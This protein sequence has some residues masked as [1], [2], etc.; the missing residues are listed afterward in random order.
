MRKKYQRLLAVILTWV[1]C[2]SLMQG[3]VRAEILVEE[4]V[5]GLTDVVVESEDDL[6]VESEVKTEEEEQTQSHLPQTFT[7]VY[8]NPLYRDVISEEDLVKPKDTETFQS[9]EEQVSAENYI[10]VNKASELFR[11][12]MKKR[13]ETI[14][15]NV[16]TDDITQ[17]MYEIPDAAMAHTGNPKEGDYLQWQYRG[18][19]CSSCYYFL[20]GKYY[21]EIIYTLTY[22]TN[23]AQ[24]AEL[25]NAIASVKSS[26]GLDSTSLSDY[27]KIKAIYDYLTENIT[28]D[29]TNLDDNDYWLKYTA[30]A[31]M[32]NRTAV[33]QGYAVLFYR[34][35][36]DAG[37][38][39]RVI[40]GIGNGGAH[41]W[42]IVKLGSFYYNIDA[43]WDAG[44]K[45]YDYFLK[46]DTNFENHIRD[47]SY[48]TAS[49]Y[50][51]YPMATSNYDA[52]HV[53][54]YGA[55]KIVKSATCIKE[56][57]QQRICITCENKETRAVNKSNHTWGAW[58]TIT[59]ATVFT[60][61][62][63]KR[64]C[65]QCN[66]A[67]E[68]RFSGEKL[69]KTISVTQSS[70][71][72]QMKQ[73]TTAFRV[74]FAN[75]DSVKSWT[76]SNTRVVKISGK[77]NGTCTITAQSKTGSATITITLK[78]GLE[79]SV[80]VNVQKGAVAASSLKLPSTKVE[81]KKG[82]TL[83]LKPI[84]TPITSQSKVTYSTS[85]KSVATVS[86]SGVIKGVKKGTAKITV[87]AGTKKVVCTVAV[88]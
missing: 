3:T 33:C 56:G 30:Y 82:K 73:K 63:Q 68:T 87:K 86:S 42:N 12:K 55:W 69:K 17:V 71:T 66:D 40:T 50:K 5:Q 36:L 67:Y 13:S 75:G 15:L 39:V 28:Y 53:H 9:E 41:A 52:N 19:S 81:V 74:T 47:H 4:D 26:L 54:Q 8:V 10:S 34:M 88:K 14:V 32:I 57:M 58:K 60:P 84:V 16:V 6:V 83:T 27:Q 65:T 72:M 76:S 20:E 77:S 78:S 48:A 23:A 24:E 31:A 80:K 18:W 79:K 29:Y 49:F 62:K 21:L 61:K 1:M 35:A 37:I 2:L 43:T 38:D 45:Y 44:N 64:T 25:D 59:A 51:T 46:T 70:L 7:E 11:E 22:Y 85:N